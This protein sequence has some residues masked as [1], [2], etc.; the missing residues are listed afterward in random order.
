MSTESPIPK[1]PSER[2]ERLVLILHPKRASSIFYYVFGV[3]LFVVGLTFMILAS[4][5]TI[6]HSILSW[7]L[8]LSAMIFGVLLIVGAETRHYFTLY[9]ITT[10]NVRV[11][12]G[13]FRRK[14]VRVFYD[15]ITLC[16]TSS[17]PEEKRVG[18]GHVEICT[19]KM[20]EKPAI[21]FDE[22]HNPDGVREIISRFVQS[23]P[24]PVPWEHLNRD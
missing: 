6:S 10:W 8:S 11:R 3:V 24:D 17:N 19:K 20:N 5:G 22:V 12:K 15:E 23:L 1:F 14:T 2:R 18:M 16:R 13:I 4:F 21:V 9:I 7:S